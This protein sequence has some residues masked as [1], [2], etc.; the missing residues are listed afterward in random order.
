M[1]NSRG[2]GRPKGG[3]TAR[4]DILTVARRRFLHDGYASVTLRSI[5]A[6]A[7]VDVA[8]I[9]YHFGSKK[10]LFGEALDLTTNPTLVVAQAVDA[11][12]DQLPERLLRGLL[13]VW[14]AP[15]RRAPLVRL[16]ERVAADPDVAQTFREMAERELFGKIAERLGDRPRQAAAV[17]AQLAGLIWLRYILRVEPL[18]S[19]TQDDVVAVM[20]PAMRAGMSPP[21]AGPPGRPRR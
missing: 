10:G 7:G 21:R 3:S 4:D 19:M 18:A 17:A 12:L 11:P 5:A 15:E 8:L 16:L 6:D 2:R 14:D 9:A 13:S 1:N 20:L